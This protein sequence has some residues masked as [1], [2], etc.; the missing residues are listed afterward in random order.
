MNTGHF[1][2]DCQNKLYYKR[3]NRNLMYNNFFK[4]LPI[5]ITPINDT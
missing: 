2:T 5:G 3:I 1:S 4:I